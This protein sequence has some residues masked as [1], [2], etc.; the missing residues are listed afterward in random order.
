LRDIKN[1][2]AQRGQEREVKNKTIFSGH[3]SWLTKFKKS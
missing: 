2:V 3:Y 1:K